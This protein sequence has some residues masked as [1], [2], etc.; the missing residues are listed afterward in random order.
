MYLGFG[1][2]AL[3][4]QRNARLS[5]ARQSKG[6][7]SMELHEPSNLYPTVYNQPKPYEPNAR[8]NAVS[9]AYT[10]TI[11]HSGGSS[12]LDAAAEPK[13][14]KPSVFTE[15]HRLPDQDMSILTSTVASSAT[16][17]PT[18]QDTRDDRLSKASRS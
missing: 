14:S 10:S 9:S 13:P 7:S 12:F 15:S 1:A 16:S 18:Y 2:F 5:V 11:R 8:S 3:H 4:L 6:G 17:P